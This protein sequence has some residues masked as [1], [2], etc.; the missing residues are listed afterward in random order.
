MRPKVPQ[1]DNATDCALYL[2]QYAECFLENPP[3]F[4]KSS[5]ES[6]S[7]QSVETEQNPND[8]MSKGNAQPNPVIFVVK[9]HSGGTV[10]KLGDPVPV[11]KQRKTRSDNQPQNLANWFTESRVKHKREEILQLIKRLIDES[12]VYHDGSMSP[13]GSSS[14]SS[15][16]MLSPS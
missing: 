11:N 5:L 12:Q 3:D 8:N 4:D 7:E 1:Q 14:G 13:R 6:S 10:L 16:L 15:P 9:G 2:F